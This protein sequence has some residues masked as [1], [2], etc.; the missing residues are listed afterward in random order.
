ADPVTESEPPA[1]APAL[2]RGRER[3][4]LEVLSVEPAGGEKALEDAAEAG[5]ETGADHAD[6]LAVVRLL[7]PALEQ[8]ALEQP[9]EAEL[10]CA[11][12]D[13]RGRPLAQRGVLCELV[14]IGGGG[15]VRGA[16]LAEQR[17]VAHEVGVAPD[18]RRE[19]AIGATREARVAEVLRVVARL[20]QR[21]QDELREGVA[22]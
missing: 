18:R 10:V 5:E 14:Q 21:P 8:L 3:V 1:A 17:A 4:Q 6:D 7:P 9:R 11:V 22:A 13:L 20:L 2:E 15:I 16:E 19:V 12:L